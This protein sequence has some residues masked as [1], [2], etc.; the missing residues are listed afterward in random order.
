MQNVALSHIGDWKSDFLLFLC[1][2]LDKI[3][4]ESPMDSMDEISK[5]LFKNRPDIMGQAAIALI[6]YRTVF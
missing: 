6:L 4:R 1:D 5:S 3:E 2:R